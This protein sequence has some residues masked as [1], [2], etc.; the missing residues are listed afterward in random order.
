M[1]YIAPQISSDAQKID[2]NS[3]P[4]AAAGKHYY[5]ESEKRK[6]R[7]D[8]AFHLQYRKRLES[9]LTEMF[10]LFL[11]GTKHNIQGKA[12]MQANMA[13]KIGPGHEELKQRFIPQMR[14]RPELVAK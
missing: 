2:E 14:S 6:F 12:Y 8:P 7:D 9:A 3:Q 4:P 5:I 11:R 1:T 10:P 13:A